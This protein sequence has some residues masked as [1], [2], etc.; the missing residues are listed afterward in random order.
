MKKILL[1]LLVAFGGFANAQYVV[2]YKKVADTYF[3]NKDYY[4]AST[5]YKKALKITGD[6]TQAI[7]PYGMERKSAT[8]DK[9]IDDYEG[10]IYNLAESSRLYREFN[11]AEKYYGIAITFTNTRFRKALFYYGESLRANKKFNLAIDAFQ[12]FIQRNPGDALAKDAQKEIESCK[13][14]IEEMRF[15]RMVQVKKMPANVNGLGSNYAPVKINNELYFTSSR[16]IAVGSKKDMVKT[17]AGEV[18][19]STKT[20]PFINNIYAAKG[21]LTSADIAVRKIDIIF[22]KS[23]EVAAATFTP[24]GNTVYFTAWKNKEKYAIYSSKKTGDKWSDPQPVGLQVNSKDFNSTQPFVTSDGKFLLFSSDRSGGYGKYDLWYCAV[25]E[26]GSLGQAVNFGPAINTE[27][28]ERAPYYNTL[29]KKLLFSTDGRI[30]FG[31]L[32]F[33]ESEGDLVNWS[34]PKNLG[35]PFNSSKDDLYFTAT[36]DKGTKGYISS[37]R[38]SSCCLEL[39]EVK[40]EYLSIAGLLTDCKTKLPLA[41]ADVTLTNAE[42]PQ[43]MTTGTDGIYR[44]KVDSKRPIKLLFAKDNYFAITK[45]YPYEELAKADTLIYKDYCLSPFKLGIPIALENVYYEFNSAELT[46]PSKKVLDFLI[47]IMEDNPEMEIELGSHTDNIGT[48]EYN[49]DLSNRRAKSCTDY[50]E[51]KG[52]AAARL[53]SKGYGESMPIAPNEIIV[54]RKKKD[55][56]EGRAKNRRTEFKV[57]KK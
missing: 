21:E 17:D 54:K 24:D 51:S 41:G 49:L 33:F 43:K 34:S 8:D 29:T 42:G 37:D 28:D 38:E 11:E 55:N 16:P 1:F 13:F 35:Y 12:Q 46:E 23:M 6:S 14:A 20:N 4:A 48:D 22:P 47:P 50:L 32:D 30:G 44:F 25:R 19:V 52:I 27:D 57:T 10:S 39:F 56:P 3:E 53:T 45:N 5:F 7:L 9:V 40:K 18:Q 2:N 15:P 31:G 36:D 26:D